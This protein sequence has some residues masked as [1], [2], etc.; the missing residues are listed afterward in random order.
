MRIREFDLLKGYAITVVVFIH[1][2][3]FNFQTYPGAGRMTLLGASTFLT[4]AIVIFF[5]VSGF[6]GYQSYAKRNNFW[7]FFSSRMKLLLPPYF[8]WSTVYLVLQIFVGGVVGFGT[9]IN[10]F[11]IITQ[12]LFGMA[13]LP[14]YYLFMLFVFYVA[15]PF[16][17]RLGLPTLKKSLYLFFVLGVVSVSVYSVPQY[18]GTVTMNPVVVYRNPLS[19]ALFYLWGLYSAKAGKLFWREGLPKLVTA[20]FFIFYA[21]SVIMVLTIPKLSDDWES[22]LLFT[23]AQYMVYIFFIPVVFSTAYRFSKRFE[24]ASS[25]LSEVGK[26]SLGIYVSHGMVLF[27]I[28]AVTVIF[29]PTLLTVADFSLQ[30]IGGALT[31]LL[32]YLI[33][34]LI[35]RRSKGL[36]RIIM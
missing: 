35:Y 18:F 3:F 20:A 2:V 13:F 25:A 29:K 11:N 16:V 7:D 30:L 10:P 34:E 32:S 6:L 33:I 4:P 22:Y 36:Y 15:T 5:F 24:R 31:I 21:L 23:P 8:I 12:Y 1:A 19:W 17:S 27:G 14:F 28:L 26:H 9:I